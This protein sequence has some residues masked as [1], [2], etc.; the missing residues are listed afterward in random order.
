MAGIS[1]GQR[2]E[3]WWSGAGSNRRPSAFQ[4]WRTPSSFPSCERCGPS[5][6]AAGS[7]WLLLLLSPLLSGAA[8][9]AA[10]RQP[11]MRAIAHVPPCRFIRLLTSATKILR[12]CAGPS[13]SRR[14]LPEA[15]ISLAVFKIASG[16]SPPTALTCTVSVRLAS[17]LHVIPRISRASASVRREAL[18]TCLQRWWQ[19]P[20]DLRLRRSS[21]LSV[22]P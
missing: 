12:A 17:C 9:P 14:S 22:T 16:Y 1:A 3:K 6:I 13:R 5:S 8:D 19:R 10:L 21:A 11:R 20:D 18:I 7:G 2:L 15:S 4:A